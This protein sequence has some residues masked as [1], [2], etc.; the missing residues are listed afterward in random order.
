[1][2]I[3]L[4][5]S[6]SPANFVSKTIQLVDTLNGSLR[7]SA[8]VV[9]PIV[10]I[11]R[12]SPIGFNY[13]RI[14]E[15]DRYYFIT[16]IATQT[17]GIVTVSMHVD[18]LMTYG[19]DIRAARAIVTR[20]EFQWNLYLDDGSFKSYQNTNHKLIPFPSGFS[21]INDF[22]FVLALAGNSE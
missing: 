2:T 12:E 19:A 6:M 14:P 4:Y 18:V 15:F 7:K 17:T 22:S 13:A 1:M 21:D 9:D 20:N 11:A 8:S 5:R 10:T 16:G 3:E